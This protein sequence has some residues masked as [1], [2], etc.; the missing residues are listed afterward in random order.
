MSLTLLKLD[1]FRNLKQAQL[2]PAAKFN[3]IYG[4]NGSGKTSVLEAIHYLSLGRSFRAR[5]NSRI[6]NYDAEQFSLFA[7]IHL[8]PTVEATNIAPQLLPVGL[9][10]RTDGEMQLRINHENARSLVE[11]TQALPVRLLHADSRLLLSGGSKLRRQFLDW[12]VFH[13]EQSFL[14]HW[15]HAQRI[16]KQRNAAL[17]SRATKDMIQLWDHELEAQA[18]ALHAMRSQYIAN[19]QAVLDPLLQELLPNLDIS[20]TYKPGWNQETALA[21]ILENSLSR[22]RELGYTQYGPQRA[23]LLIRFDR[24]IP[25]HEALSQGQQKLL[26][27]GLHLAQGIL[28]KQQLNKRCVYL[29]DDLPAE[30]DS[31]NRGR[32]AAVLNKMDAQVFVTAVDQAG[33]LDF[34][35]MAQTQL[36]HVQQGAIMLA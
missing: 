1:N 31:A 30:L 13:V 22:D 17:R 19:F 3:L 8:N 2:E 16:L 7:Q 15:Q 14:Q 6:I 24:S 27:Y 32:V 35:Q 10:R 28:L 26:V 9:L 18:T 20:I 11:V 5:L 12:G 21:G 34:S 4:H 29:L 36:F 33:L 23:D 25:A